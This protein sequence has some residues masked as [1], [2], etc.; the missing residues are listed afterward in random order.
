MPSPHSLQTLAK[1]ILATQQ[2]ST[3]HYFI[4]KYCGLWWHGAPIMLST[5]EDNQ[6]MIKSASFKEGLSL[7]LALM[8]VVQENNHDLI[9]LFTEWGA[10]INSSF[11]TVNMECTRN[12]CRELGAKEA[13]NERDIL[14]IFYKTRDIKTSSHVILCH[15]L[16]SNNPLFQNI[17]RMRSIIYRSLEKLS[18][19]FILDDISFSEMLTRHWYGL[20]ILYN[21]TEA[22][23]YFYE[24]YKHFKNWRLICGLSFN[25]LS[26]LYEIYNLEKVD[27]NID[28]MMYLACSIYDGNYSTIYYCFVLGADINQAMLT[29]VINHCIGNL[30]LCIDLGAD[31]F[32]DSMELAKQKNDNIFISILSFKNYSPDSSLLSLKMTD[33]EK[34][35]ALLDEEKYESKNML[36]F[37]AHD[38]KTSTS[39]VRL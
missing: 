37:D 8:K 21:L 6:L 14:Q 25:N 4:L 26:D 15:E 28:E 10:D 5:N 12:L 31:A 32:E 7:D 38:E 27:M 9:K 17:E 1:K 39:P 18:I 24:K 11:V 29:S 3:D 19:N 20:A 33:P 13:L 35:N 36:M 22:I 16:L 2:I 23:Q 34:I 30:F